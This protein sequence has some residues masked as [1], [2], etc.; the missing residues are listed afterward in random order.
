V[1]PNK[2]AL[3]GSHIPSLHLWWRSLTEQCEINDKLDM[4]IKDNEII[5]KAVKKSLE[6]DGLKNLKKWQKM[7]MIN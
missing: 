5:L 7:E 3:S 6:M 1:A 2:T 4:E